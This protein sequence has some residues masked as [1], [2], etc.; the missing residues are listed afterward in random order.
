MNKWPFSETEITLTQEIHSTLSRKF[1]LHNGGH[2]HIKYCAICKL[3]ND[4]KPI[5][6]TDA[7]WIGDAKYFAY[8]VRIKI[9]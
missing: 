8:Y 6:K 2:L 3:F 7:Q 5:S 4:S 9:S 1:N